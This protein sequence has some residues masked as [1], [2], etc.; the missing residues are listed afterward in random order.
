MD[1]NAILDEWTI[2]LT[3]RVDATGSPPD[4]WDYTTLL[5]LSTGIG[6]QVWVEDAKLNR[7]GTEEELDA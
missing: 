3:L 4:N 1:E 5:D 6:E 7:T 2:T